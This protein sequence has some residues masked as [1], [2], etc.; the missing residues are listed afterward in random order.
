MALNTQSLDRLLM[1]IDDQLKRDPTNIYLI[2]DRNRILL[3]KMSAQDEE[4]DDDSAVNTDVT[5]MLD[6][7]SS[8]NSDSDV[9]DIIEMET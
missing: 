3:L 5:P 2:E 7:S 1:L 4:T 8:D 6:Y 9:S